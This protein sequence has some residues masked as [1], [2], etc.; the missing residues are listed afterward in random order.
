MNRV[1]VLLYIRVRIPTSIPMKNV[2]SY[3][4]V[5]IDYYENDAI[6]LIEDKRYY[7]QWS[8]KTVPTIIDALDFLK[9]NS[10]CTD[11]NPK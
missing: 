7:F 2:I 8:G 1:T 9:N 5:D 11:K 3:E 6:L 10:C 4:I